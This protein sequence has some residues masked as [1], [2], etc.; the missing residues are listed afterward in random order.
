MEQSHV[1]AVVCLV[2]TSLCW[3]VCGNH[4][5]PSLQVE[6]N[7]HGK[8]F[9]LE[10]IP[11]DTVLQPVLGTRDTWEVQLE[12]IREAQQKIDFWAMYWALLDTAGY[13]PEQKKRL[14]RRK[15]RM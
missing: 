14:G 11:R 13:S 10:S 6:T 9:L 4:Q 8:A 7:L 1:R 15:I 2:I 3:T 12:F 5:I